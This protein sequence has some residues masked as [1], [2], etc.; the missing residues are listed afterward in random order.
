MKVL[1]TFVSYPDNP[2]HPALR[3]AERL[4]LLPGQGRDHAWEQKHVKEKK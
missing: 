4:T 1:F 3:P 2:G